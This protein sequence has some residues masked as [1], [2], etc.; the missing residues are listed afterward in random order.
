M[1]SYPP[2]VQEA[3]VL[4]QDRFV[5]EAPS[6][7]HYERGSL[8]YVLMSVGALL[9]M[10]YAVWTQN[11]LFA[12]LVLLMAIILI[13]AGNEPARNVLVQVGDNGIVVD[14][15]LFLF[16]DVEQFAIVYQPP[17][18]K[19]LY[20]DHRNPVIPRLTIPLEEQNPLELRDHLKRYAREDLDLQDEHLS[21]M[22]ARLLKI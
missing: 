9:L 1:I 11:F 4:S 21:D 16:Q 7:I 18:T 20:I 2:E 14:G 5:W 10:A 19:I 17:Y 8:W 12:F 22:V 13:L 15:K 6:R 3:L